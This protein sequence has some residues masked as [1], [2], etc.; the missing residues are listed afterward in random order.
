MVAS[1]NVVGESNPIENTLDSKEKQHKCDCKEPCE[2]CTC[3][4]TN[5]DEVPL[6]RVNKTIKKDTKKE[7]NPDTSIIDSTDNL[8]SLSK[9]GFKISDETLY[10]FDY[11]SYRTKKNPLSENANFI[12]ETRYLLNRYSNAQNKIIKENGFFDVCRRCARMIACGE[13]LYTDNLDRIKVI[14][15]NIFLDMFNRRFLFNSPALF[16]LGIDMIAIPE[17]SYLIYDKDDLTL[18]EYKKLYSNISKYQTCFACF[19]L[20]VDDTLI[21]IYDSVKNAAIISQ[22][23]GG[24]G[25]NFGRTRE[26]GAP[27]R[28]GMGGVSSGP[29]SWMRQWNEMAT[30][31][32]QGGRR[33][34]A[35][36]GMLDVN[37]PDI[38][39]FIS[40]KDDDNV[41]SFFNISVSIT[42]EFMECVFENKPFTLRSRV[43]SSKDIEINARQLWYAICA[44]AHKRG[45]PGIHFVDL[46]NQDNLLKLNSNWI[47]EATN[48]CGEMN[49][50]FKVDKDHKNSY[51]ISNRGC[52]PRDDYKTYDSKFSEGGTS[53]N[54]GSIN[55]VKF[56]NEDIDGSKYFDFKEFAEQVRRSTYYLDLVIDVSSYPLEGIK[57]NT[58]AIRPVGLGI[59]GIHDAGIMLDIPFKT[60]DGAPFAIL[61]EDVA[62][63]MGIESLLATTLIVTEIG[64][65]PFDEVECAKDLFIEYAKWFVDGAESYLKNINDKNYLKV[66]DSDVIFYDNYYKALCEK[67]DKKFMP[68]SIKKSLIALYNIN[69]KQFKHLIYNLTSGNIRNSRR[70]SIAPTGTISL[71]CD[72]SSGIEPNFAYKW[73]RRVNVMDG[74]GNTRVEE[75]AYVHP[76][77]PNELKDEL[78]EHG[79]ILSNEIY[80]GALEINCNDHMGIVKIFAEYIDASISKTI[81]MP[82]ETTIEEIQHI[83]MEA[84]KMGIKGITIYRDGSRSY[85]P[86]S[87]GTQKKEYTDADIKDMVTNGNIDTIIHNLSDRIGSIESI[88]EIKE[89]ISGIYHILNGNGN[90][91]KELIKKISST[92]SEE[93]TTKNVVVDIKNELHRRR[94]VNGTGSFLQLKT[95]Y[96]TIHV[97]AKFNEFDEMREVFITLNKSGQELKAVT[98]ALSRLISIALQES[99]DYKSTY[100]RLIKT[101]RGISGFEAWV[102]DIVRTDEEVILRSISDSISHVLPDLEYL[103]LLNKYGTKE[104]ALKRMIY[105]NMMKK[106]DSADNVPIPT[107]I[108]DSNKTVNRINKYKGNQCPQCGSKHYYYSGGCD[109]CLSCG[110]SACSS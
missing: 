95:P 39:E 72:V 57:L 97:A 26:K 65:R 108:D 87:T 99:V 100:R 76:L 21:G 94:P 8:V 89:A 79:R 48:P 11:D 4:K 14:E 63:T 92:I 58:Q 70:L 84:Y 19:V 42:D 25:T 44:H 56:V 43:D 32:V 53:C 78:M 74:H 93:S 75:R 98:E 107:V 16:N 13:T 7:S 61:C 34:A 31:V 90:E 55:V 60:S 81:N 41:L 29:I 59:M 82:N 110:Y 45:D 52:V 27:V 103:Y 64:K 51:S 68:P 85:Q 88:E 109:K 49:L 24:V 15:H 86:L 23:G 105:T 38:M 101:L 106:D 18:D 66:I 104:E 28:S 9:L 47:I 12:L 2:N 54:L 36:M 17:L 96:G 67:D 73:T 71:L 33:R 50:P 35:L 6:K 5:H 10:D 30:Q 62:K 46:S 91:N 20:P 1:K 40:C 37:H 22:H 83:Y 3:E 80:K 77:I 102:H 69:R